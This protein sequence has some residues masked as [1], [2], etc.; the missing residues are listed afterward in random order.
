MYDNLHWGIHPLQFQQIA[1][2][3]TLRS[4]RTQL[5]PKVA[6]D[7]QFSLE[8]KKVKRNRLTATYFNNICATQERTDAIE[9]HSTEGLK[10]AKEVTVMGKSVQPK[11]WEAKV[12]TL[13]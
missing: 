13:F 2:H 9:S 1:G 12:C 3:H 6:A 4:T 11:N 10:T 5:V 7:E 8:I